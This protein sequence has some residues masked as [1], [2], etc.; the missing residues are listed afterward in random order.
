M[1]NR[2]LKN[3][4]QFEPSETEISEWRERLV[5]YYA[6]MPSFNG[7]PIEKATSIIE[8]AKVGW[9]NCPDN[10]EGRI[11]M[12]S[13]M[14]KKWKD[15]LV[16][17]GVARREEGAQEAILEQE[18][19]ETHGRAE[20]KVIDDHIGLNDL[21]KRLPA[22]DRKFFKQRWKYYNKEFD[23]NSS[24]DYALL[25]E[26]CVDELEQKRIAQARL[27]CDPS[28]HDTL[29]ILSKTASECLT[30]L[31][32]SLKALGVTREQ[33]KDEMDDSA[34]SIAEVSL[35]LDRKLK[36]Q[37]ARHRMELEE[38]KDMLQIKYNKNDTYPVPGLVRPLHN[39]IPDMAEI[40]KLTRGAV[41]SIGE[42]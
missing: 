15:T 3:P 8:A 14:K 7:D 4:T 12:K 40:L 36:R 23:I 31:E 35:L 34:E 28:D 33:R 16:P 38:E 2:K 5:S 19:I 9:R 6:N 39:R 41:D 1:P 13:K 22:A 26:I 25:M 37:E 32:R 27:S 11:I 24:S 42:E 30:R 29:S 17:R 18:Y 20:Q 10:F 21:L